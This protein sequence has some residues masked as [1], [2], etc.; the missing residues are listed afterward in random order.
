MIEII[1]SI[2]A[3]DPHNL[4]TAVKKVEHCVKKIH[5]DIMDGKFVEGK[6]FG[7][8]IVE[9]LDT[10]LHKQV[11][12]M[13]MNPELLIE[14]YAAAGAKTLIIHEESFDSTEKLRDVLKR[15]KKLGRKAGVSLNPETP[16]MMIKPVLKDIDL[17]L[18]MTV[19]PGRGGQEMIMKTLEKVRQIRKLRRKIDIEVDGGVNKKTISKA[20]EAGANMFVCGYSIFS[21]QDP[22][23]AI[24][25]L[26]KAV[27]NK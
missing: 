20:A 10:K 3:A 6:T 2:L 26:R 18:V 4:Q 23:E 17:V 8:E 12:L 11:H 15:I 21:Q 13:A 19:H 5:I 9:L 27:K 14:E 7:P 24:K 22:A 16:V 25:E 1:P